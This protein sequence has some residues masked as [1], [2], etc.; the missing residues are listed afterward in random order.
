MDRTEHFRGKLFSGDHLLFD[1]IQGQL[2]T[3]TRGGGPSEWSGYF[4]FPA[5]KRETLADGSLY[6][7]VLIDG[8]SGTV[9]VHVSDNDPLGRSVANFHGTGMARR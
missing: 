1:S 5:E 9:H 3:H 8:R 2:K 6:R 7:I 4:E